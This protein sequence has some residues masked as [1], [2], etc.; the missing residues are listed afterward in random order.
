VKRLVVVVV[1]LSFALV[2]AA[3][4]AKLTYKTQ[5][6]AERY[7]EHGLKQWAGVN[8]RSRKYKFHVAFCLPGARSK[9]E[10]RHTHFKVHTTAAGEKLYHSFAC[11]LAAADKVWHLYLTARPNGTYG[12]RTDA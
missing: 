11:T 1:A 12:V 6:Q 3:G 8:L 10:Q 9:Y 4:A 2:P 7:L 5:R